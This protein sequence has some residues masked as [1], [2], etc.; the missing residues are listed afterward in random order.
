MGYTV[1]PRLH[2]HLYGHEITVTCRAKKGFPR[3]DRYVMSPISKHIQ[4]LISCTKAQYS[5]GWLPCDPRSSINSKSRRGLVQQ[6][7]VARYIFFS[8][9]SKHGK[10]SITSTRFPSETFCR[11]GGQLVA[12]RFSGFW[13]ASQKTSLVARK[14]ARR[15]PDCAITWH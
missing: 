1:L 5:W 4:R 9:L 10:D 6:H 14:P 3:A 11:R 13:L 7:S 8:G 2:S 15:L 12:C